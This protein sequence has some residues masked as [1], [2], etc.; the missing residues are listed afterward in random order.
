MVEAKIVPRRVPLVVVVDGSFTR[1][2]VGVDEAEA[3]RASRVTLLLLAVGAG[4]A[5]EMHFENNLSKSDTALSIAAVP[6]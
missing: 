4:E 3:K 5:E 6:G 1:L 2:Q